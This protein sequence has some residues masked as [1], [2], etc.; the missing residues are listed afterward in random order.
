MPFPR[1]TISLG[2]GAGLLL[3]AAG[4][5]SAN[6]PQVYT[7]TNDVNVE[8]FDCGSFV[9]HGAWSISHVLTIY[10]D[11]AG[12]P[13]RDRE[14]VEFT[15]AFV[16]PN[17]GASIRDAGQIIYFDTLD[18]DGNFLT[19]MK[20]EVR[21]S[22]YFQVAGRTDFQSGAHHGVDRFD[23]NIPAACAALGA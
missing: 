18:A 9:A 21:H 13:L 4:T 5:A 15:G 19:T 12:T 22:D 23:V 14:K 20:N 8:Y 10:T 3:T 6:A 16:N 11:T 1:R 7:W 2:L 17:T